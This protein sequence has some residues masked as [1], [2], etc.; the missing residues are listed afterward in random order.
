MLPYDDGQRTW[1]GIIQVVLPQGVVSRDDMYHEKFNP[2]KREP[3]DNPEYPRH[4]I[5]VRIFFDTFYEA[6]SHIGI[7]SSS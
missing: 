4:H 1:A 3:N 7:I 6:V 2:I 5:M